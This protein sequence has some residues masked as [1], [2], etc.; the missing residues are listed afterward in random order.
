MKLSDLY[1]F[2]G[3][4]IIIYLFY[5]VF[6]VLRHK[7]INKKRVPVELVYLIKKYKID[8][9]KIKY[10]SIMNKIA[11]VSAFDISFIATFVMRFIDNVYLAILLGGVLFIP[12]IMITYSFIGMYYQKKGLI[13]DG[14]KKD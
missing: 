6:Q 2:L 12:L 7:K 9:D 3:T 11:L 10:T 1:W 14:D 8:V 5:L 13:K 4:F